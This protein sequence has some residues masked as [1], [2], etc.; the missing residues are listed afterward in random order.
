MRRERPWLEWLPP[1]MVGASV[2]VAAEV[3]V[4][5][6]LYGGPGFVRSLTTIL[7]VAGFAF[8]G[9]LWSSPTPGPELVERIRRRWLGCLF[10][11]LAAAVYGTAWSIVPWLGEDRVGQGFGLAL[12]AGVPLYGAGAVLGGMSVV[13][14]TDE[15]GR[16]SAPGAAASVGA[17]L[18]FV[19]TGLA[20]PRAPMPASL[21]VVCLVM[22]S[23]G[24]MVYG[25]VLGWRTQIEVKA[26]RPGRGEE[27]VVRVRRVPADDVAV[28]ELYE[29]HW[30]RRGRHEEGRDEAPWDV[31]VVRA[32]LPPGDTHW[33][34]LVV[35][36]GASSAPRVVL[37]EHPH[38]TVHVLERSAAVVELGR[39]YF[40]TALSVGA[41]DRCTVEVGNLDD[42]IAG[43]TGRHDLVLVD[44]IALA[45]VGGA[46]GLSATSRS[47]LFDLV[48]PEPELIRAPE[49]MAR[50]VIGSRRLE[51]VTVIGEPA[52]LA[53]LPPG[54]EAEITRSAVP[55][56]EASMAEGS[57][58]G[59]VAEADAR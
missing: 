39:E 24:G 49:R 29:G 10:A 48:R 19:L 33:S 4:A 11:F 6:L 35:G 55:D 52:V 36:G 3:A 23:L 44:T 53:A 37:R 5:V 25:S 7:A 20:L 31:E 27:V 13:A 43:L 2:A 42:G 38:G 54:L 51:E 59:T 32:L 9:G 15:G 41:S 14:G 56:S 28:V 17:A 46:T 26:R 30:L 58:A 45:R 40:D 47:G 50:A 8:A 21:L 12:L 34:V 57:G 16:L 18:G 1:L 22:L